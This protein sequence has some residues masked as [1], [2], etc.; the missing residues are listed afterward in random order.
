MVNMK[1]REWEK[2][3]QSLN[4]SAENNT[5]RAAA[6]FDIGRLRNAFFYF[7]NSIA[8]ISLV[9]GIRGTVNKQTEWASALAAPLQMQGTNSKAESRPSS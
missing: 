2:R 4:S 6:M 7:C 5:R 1:T 8:E 3:K 9:S